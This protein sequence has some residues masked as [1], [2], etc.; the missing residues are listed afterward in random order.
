MGRSVKSIFEWQVVIEVVIEGIDLNGL[1]LIVFSR[2]IFS[3]GVRVETSSEAA[4]K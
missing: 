2:P 3:K 4:E 1:G